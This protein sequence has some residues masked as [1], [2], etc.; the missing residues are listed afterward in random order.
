MKKLLALAVVILGFTAVSFGQATATATSS[1]TIIGPISL[2]KNIDMNFGN[3]AVTTTAGTVVLAPDG[4]RTITGGVTLPAV[5][6]TVS[7]A[8]FTVGGEGTSTF[9]ITLPSTALT[10]TSGGNT[11][12]ATAFS[13]NPIG[14]GTLI[15]GSKI[16]AVGATLNV[17]SGQATGTYVSVP[18]PVTVNYN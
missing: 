7:Q 12:T 13:S 11:M 5:T 3:V 8:S 9:S 2:T 6:G 15:A 17:A 16:I 4:T 14:T 1:A 10:L 18:F